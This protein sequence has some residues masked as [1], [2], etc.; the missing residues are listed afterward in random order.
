MRRVLCI[1][2]W[3][4]EARQKI[5]TPK[6]SSFYVRSKARLPEA[7]KGKCPC[8]LLTFMIF[9]SNAWDREADKGEGRGQANDMSFNSPDVGKLSNKA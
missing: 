3:C 9:H 4:S 5:I 8:F 1:G 2:C 7:T 6:S